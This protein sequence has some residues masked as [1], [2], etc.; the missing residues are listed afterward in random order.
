MLLLRSNSTSSTVADC[1]STTNTSST[2]ESDMTEVNVP[3]WSEQE[4][5]AVADYWDLSDEYKK[6]L[7]ELG[8]RLRDINHPRNCAEEVAF[9]LMTTYGKVE[10]TE[11]MFRD[12]IRWREKVG[13]DTIIQ[14]PPPQEVIDSIPGAILKGED[15]EGDPI[16]LDRFLSCDIMGLSKKYNVDTLVHHAVWIRE[17]GSQG[18]WREDWEKRKGKKLRQITVIYDVEGLSRKFLT[19]KKGI[20]AYGEVMR[21]D[22]DYYPE[23]FKRYVSC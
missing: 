14:N 23:S 18:A 2:A 11:T 20:Q 6:A 7:Y 13:A 9:F 12:C 21:L 3:G 8:Y 4:I 5:E 15:L 17:A 10:K 22:Q 1:C 19:H 16:F